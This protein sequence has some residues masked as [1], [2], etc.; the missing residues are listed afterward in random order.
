MRSV[1][2]VPTPQGAEALPAASRTPDDRPRWFACYTHGR[3]EKRVDDLLRRAGIESYLPVRVE[4]RRWS[5][6]TKRIA[7]PLFPSYVFA[8]C[9][10]AE[11]PRVVQT[12]GIVA[13]VQSRGQPTAI[14]DDEIEHVRLL[15]ERA[16]THGIEIETNDWVAEGERVRVARGAFQ[17]IEGV[18]LHA[19]EGSVR[20]L[21]GVQAIRG[22]LAVHVPKEAVEPVDPLRVDPLRSVES[23]PS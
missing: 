18:A 2:S 3:H 20:V 16:R 6:R 7:F 13:M 11:L 23:G 21:V 5:D 12:T 1:S 17:G 14:H 9:R 22:G 15:E 19:R 4:S 8:R 10:L